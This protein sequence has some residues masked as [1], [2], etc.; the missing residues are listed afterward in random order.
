MEMQYKINKMLE[1]KE[2][3]QK[4][5][6]NETDVEEDDEIVDK[7]YEYEENHQEINNMKKQN[8]NENADD[9]E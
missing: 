8:T 4:E 2:K 9:K 1:E 5:I 6:E 7:K 3:N